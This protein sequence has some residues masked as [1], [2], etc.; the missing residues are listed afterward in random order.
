MNAGVVGGIVSQK[1][2]ADVRV[3]RRGIGIVE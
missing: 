3:G 1:S 2:R